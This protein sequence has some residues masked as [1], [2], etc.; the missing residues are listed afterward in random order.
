MGWNDITVE[1][2]LWELDLS[3]PPSV[4][5]PAHDLDLLVSFLPLGPE[6]HFLDMG[7]GSGASAIL[8]A[9][10]FNC[11]HVLAVDINQG[12]CMTTVPNSD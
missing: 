5:I 1:V 11:K 9:Q 7:T 12:I 2:K 10:K 6:S 3:V 4:H 8:V